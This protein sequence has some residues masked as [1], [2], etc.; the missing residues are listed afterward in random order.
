[1]LACNYYLQAQN[2]NV[3]AEYFII[4]QDTLTCVNVDQ[5]LDKSKKI[6]YKQDLVNLDSYLSKG[7]NQLL[8]NFDTTLTI[9]QNLLLSLDTQK[10]KIIFDESQIYIFG[11][12]TIIYDKLIHGYK[13]LRNAT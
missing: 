11:G 3:E 5:E 4:L 9:K 8:L 10:L 2:N 12:H 7:V 1:M 13:C 6:K